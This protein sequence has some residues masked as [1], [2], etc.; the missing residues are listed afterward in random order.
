MAGCVYVVA[1]GD[2]S[3]GRCG[4]IRGELFGR[5]FLGDAGPDRLLCV[6]PSAAGEVAAGGEVGIRDTPVPAVG[7]PGFR[8]FPSCYRGVCLVFTA[9]TDLA[10]VGTPYREPLALGGGKDGR[11]VAGVTDGVYCA[12][13]QTTTVVDDEGVV[14]SD[15]R[16][17]SG[18]VGSEGVTVLRCV[19]SSFGGVA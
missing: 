9:L 16:S 2:G 6:E 11:A 1:E 13:G 3:P 4:M 15:G 14:R 18:H 5:G 19:L 8:L 10:D 12:A 7:G 17:G